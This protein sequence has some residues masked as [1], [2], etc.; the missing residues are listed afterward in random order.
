[1]GAGAVW[2][3]TRFVTARESAASKLGKKAII[4]TSMCCGLLKAGTYRII[5]AGFEGTMR[6]TIWTG[7]PLRALAT[8]Y[9]RH[10]ELNRREVIGQLQNQGLAVLDY[11]LDKLARQGKPMGCGAAMVNTPDQSAHEI[12][13]EMV[14]RA[15]TLLRDTGQYVN[16]TSKL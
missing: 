4:P 2:V 1:M 6:G 12:V 16:Q 11:E 5:D 3:G 13:V 8:P 7:R 9:I 15:F 10:W 14:T